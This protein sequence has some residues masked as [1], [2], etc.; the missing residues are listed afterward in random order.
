M[1]AGTVNLQEARTEVIRQLY[2]DADIIEGTASSGSTTTITDIGAGIATTPT[3]TLESA[4]NSTK[5]FIAN[6]V[7]VPAVTAPKDAR[8]ASYDIGAGTLTL[9]TALGATAGTNPY[10][11][12]YELPPARINEIIVNRARQGSHGALTTIAEATA[13]AFDKFVLADGALADCYRQIAIGKRPEER[14]EYLALAD[15][16]EAFWLAGLRLQGYQGTYRDPME[17][18]EIDLMRPRV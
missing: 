7:Y 5:A 17:N 3:T 6:F 10:E 18:N 11:L 8:V 15:M 12:H 2:A 14:D 9:A 13:I 4:L 16:H 1:A